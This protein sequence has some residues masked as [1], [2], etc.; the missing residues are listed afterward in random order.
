MKKL[1]IV[2]VTSCPT[3]VA[4]TFMAAEALNKKAKELGHNIK[5]ETRGSVG[6]QNE[7]SDE[8]I[9]QCDLVIIAA[10]IAVDK[11]KFA[12]KPIYETSTSAALKQGDVVFSEAIALMEN[13]SPSNDTT[14]NNANEDKKLFE[15]KEKKGAYK[16]LMNGV[17][18]ML[19][20]VVAG[21]LLIALA[22]AFDIKAYEIANINFKFLGVDVEV[23]HIL[24]AIFQIGAANAFAMMVPILSGY[25]AYSIADRPALAPGIVGGML[26]GVTGAGFLGG[27]ASGFLAGYLIK[28]MKDKIKLPASL[29][30]LLPTLILPFFGVLLVGLAMYYI[31]GWPVALLN[32][33][34]TSWL[35][36]LEGTN[37]VLLG[38]I[39]GGMMAVDLGG[40]VNKASYVTAT[41]LLAS[42]ISGPMAAVMAAGMTPP[43]AMF[44]VTQFYK[45]EFTIEEQESGKA[46]GV[47][48]LAFITEG[49][50]PFAARDP[51][52]VLSSCIIGSAITGG[53][54][55]LFQIT[56]EAPHGGIF[57]FIGINKVLLYI[58]CIA[59]GSLI[60]ATTYVAML[61]TKKTN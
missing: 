3:G 56:S 7:L 40:P 32:G 38:L 57:A 44:L 1:N 29:Q 26:A 19:P 31:I 59:I 53:L 24:N 50:I 14:A 46:A 13:Y 37:A 28:W 49:A 20:F 55:M 16:H 47:L 48:G 43:I 22:F 41:G 25:I 18:F 36:S 58:A 10:D 34:L 45:K 39:M 9:Q 21:G 33:A 4:H 5:V 23:P 61:M 54:V 15:K 60:S 30:S 52:K 8:E 11:S 51:F 42:N 12:G 27:I 6:S 2:A 17:S 35:Q